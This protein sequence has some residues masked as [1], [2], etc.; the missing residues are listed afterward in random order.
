MRYVHCTEED[1]VKAVKSLEKYAEKA[2]SAVF[3][4][5]SSAAAIS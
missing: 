4:P 5:A 2:T 1:Y 3:V